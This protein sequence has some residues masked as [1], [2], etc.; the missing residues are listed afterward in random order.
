MNVAA[1]RAVPHAT[2]EAR[3]KLARSIPVRRMAYL[4]SVTEKSGGVGEVSRTLGRVYCA[5]VTNVESGRVVWLGDCKCRKGLLPF[6]LALGP[7]GRGKFPGA[8]SDLGYQPILATR[9]RHA[10]HVLDRFPIV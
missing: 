10:V 8:V 2:A 1:A 3:S 6:L 5:I 9:L 4:M 7:R